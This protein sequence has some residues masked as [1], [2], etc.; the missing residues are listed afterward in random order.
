MCRSAMVF[1]L[2]ALTLSTHALPI[3]ISSSSPSTTPYDTDASNILPDDN[4]NNNRIP[5]ETIRRP[6]TISVKV[7]MDVDVD[8][9]PTEE[10]ES[11]EAPSLALGVVDLEEEE[12]DYEPSSQQPSSGGIESHNLLVDHYDEVLSEPGP[13]RLQAQDYSSAEVDVEEMLRW[14]YLN[15]DQF[16]S[17][18][19]EQQDEYEA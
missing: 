10:Q 14:P 7:D 3:D 11:E 15:L 8:V 18:S 9:R 5:F 12:E 6:I 13:H 17:R 1:G 4:N 16:E 2:L 19:D